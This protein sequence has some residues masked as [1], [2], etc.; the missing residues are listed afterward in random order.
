[1][2]GRF[3]QQQSDS[4]SIANLLSMQPKHHRHPDDPLTHLRKLTSENHL[5]EDNL[6]ATIHHPF[7]PTSV[8]FYPAT[9][10]H[11]SVIQH[12]PTVSA[13]DNINVKLEESMLI[14]KGIPTSSS[15]GEPS[16]NDPS[17]AVDSADSGIFDLENVL[18]A[19]T[20]IFKRLYGKNWLPKNETAD[21]WDKMRSLTVQ[22]IIIDASSVSESFNSINTTNKKLFFKL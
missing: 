9:L 8:P 21:E 5:P 18:M 3:H 14:D 6:L 11:P 10:G 2:E 22:G 1:M 15:A 19:R 4:F 12:P 17:T 16:S 20:A 13:Q 7:H